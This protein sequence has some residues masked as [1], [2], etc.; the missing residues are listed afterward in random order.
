MHTSLSQLLARVP[1]S[2]VCTNTRKNITFPLATTEA[3]SKDT[4]PSLLLPLHKSALFPLRSARRHTVYLLL[5]ANSPGIETS[6]LRKPRVQ[7]AH[8]TAQGKVRKS[9]LSDSRYRQT[10]CSMK[11]HKTIWSVCLS[12]QR[13][14]ENYSTCVI[15]PKL[16]I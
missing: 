13:R 9:Y 4:A 3:Y 16:D 10:R 14:K 5:N 11:M 7:T 8:R 2:A 15:Q 12:K 6:N 1:S